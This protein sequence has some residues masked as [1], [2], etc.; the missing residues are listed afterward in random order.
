[1]DKFPKITF[2]KVAPGTIAHEFVAGVAP[3]NV[4][5]MFYDALVQQLKQLAPDEL[6]LVPTQGR[7]AGN[8][9]KTLLGR[10]MVRGLDYDFATANRAP[11]GQRYPVGHKPWRFH[12]LWDGSKVRR[13]NGPTVKK[14][15]P[16]ELVFL[17]PPTPP[18][19]EGQ[20]SVAEAMAALLK[21]GKM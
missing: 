13:L 7:T 17:T 2:D 5:T 9:V 14:R 10:G 1:M 15:T 21:Y 8:V 6:V 12:R 4:S 19:L 3:V 16:P 11:D 20:V 18:L